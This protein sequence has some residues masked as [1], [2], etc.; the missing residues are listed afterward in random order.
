VRIWT[1]Y[2]EGSSFALA[3]WWTPREP[4]FW[5]IGHRGTVYKVPANWEMICMGDPE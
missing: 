2:F 3:F 1:E 5:G 4:D